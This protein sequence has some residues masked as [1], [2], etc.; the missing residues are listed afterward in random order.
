MSYECSFSLRKVSLMSLF[1]L[2]LRASAAL[3]RDQNPR[4]QPL[5]LVHS[6]YEPFTA[7]RHRYSGRPYPSLQMRNVRLRRLVSPAK[8]TQLAAAELSWA[9]RHGS[10]SPSTP[11]AGCPGNQ[12][13][14]ASLPNFPEAGLLV[15]SPNWNRGSHFCLKYLSVWLELVSSKTYYQLHFFLNVVSFKVQIALPFKISMLLR[16]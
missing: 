15:F 1:T 11:R 4:Q 12:V 7:Q 3:G 14:D 10:L 16:F 13:L 2:F 8:G 5:P 6:S 9:R